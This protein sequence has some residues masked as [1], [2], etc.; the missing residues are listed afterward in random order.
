MWKLGSPPCTRVYKEDIPSYTLAARDYT[1]RTSHH[2]SYT[3]AAWMQKEPMPKNLK[4][5][6]NKAYAKYRVEKDQ[7]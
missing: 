5:Q 4:G 3:L 2:T 7:L 1:R 6:G